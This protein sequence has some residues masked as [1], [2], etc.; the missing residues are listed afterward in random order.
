MIDDCIKF[1]KPTKKAPENLAAH[2]S[3]ISDTD[4]TSSKES[5]SSSSSFRT[6]DEVDELDSSSSISSL[7]VEEPKTFGASETEKDPNSLTRNSLSSECSE[8]STT[9][10]DTLSKISEHSKITLSAKTSLKK[11]QPRFSKQILKAVR[12]S[13]HESNEMSEFTSPSEFNFDTYSFD[14]CLKPV[15]RNMQT[16]PVSVQIINIV[17]KEIKNETIK[18][19]VLLEVQRTD[20][21]TVTIY[22][23]T[24]YNNPP[25]ESSLNASSACNNLFKAQLSRY[26]QAMT[27]VNQASIE[28]KKPVCSVVNDN[29]KSINDFDY[30]QFITLIFG[31]T[32]VVLPCKLAYNIF[33]G[34]WTFFQG[35]SSTL[36]GE[37]Y[38]I[39]LQRNFSFVHSFLKFLFFLLLKALIVS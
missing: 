7:T 21:I 39:L 26:K 30:D 38:L 33:K 3:K 13:S 5:A 37:F 31:N 18:L 6:V 32:I 15:N 29:T 16:A 12:F 17:P 23:K 36:L 2:S 35:S 9:S 11:P 14:K 22:D 25:A 34:I 19:A 1:A 24:P 20:N 8:Q 10:Q 4:L 27:S 28:N